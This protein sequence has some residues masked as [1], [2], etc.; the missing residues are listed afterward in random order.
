MKVSVH[1]IRKLVNYLNDPENWDWK[2][3]NDELHEG[4]MLGLIRLEGMDKSLVY[5][6]FAPIKDDK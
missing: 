3:S 2:I 1:T 6:K 4:E 5:P